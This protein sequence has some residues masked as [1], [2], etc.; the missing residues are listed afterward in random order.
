ME[1]ENLHIFSTTGEI[2]IT[3]SGKIWLMTNLKVTKKQDHN[4]FPENTILEK[5]EKEW[6]GGIDPFPLTTVKRHSYKFDDI[7]KSVDCTPSQNKGIL[8]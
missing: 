2:S 7:S 4:L 1:G 6:E 5:S 3:F 8:A